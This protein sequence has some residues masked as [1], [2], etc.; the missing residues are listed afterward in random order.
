MANTE[1]NSPNI[2][3]ML[4]GYKKEG[5]DAMSAVK[6][7]K[8]ELNSSQSQSRVQGMA[9]NLR[10]GRH[11]LVGAAHLYSSPV[12][13]FVNPNAWRK[14][15]E[16][17]KI[18]EIAPGKEVVVGPIIWKSSNIPA[19]GHYCYICYLESSLEPFKLPEKFAS[20]SAFE[21][22]VGANKN[23]AWRNINVIKAKTS[24]SS[25]QGLMRM[26]PKK[27]ASFSFIM[28]GFETDNLAYDLKLQSNLPPVPDLM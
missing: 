5:L 17:L 1:K 16:P 26:A 20:I 25:T 7:L 11:L 24:R 23:V 21:D 2:Q 28:Q 6:K 14:I 4:A 18:N 3:T 9:A 19:P 12:N 27:T 15:G 13:T 10:L 22:F 8:A